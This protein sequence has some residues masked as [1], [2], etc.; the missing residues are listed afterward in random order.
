MVHEATL[1]DDRV[2]ERRLEEL[3]FALDW[4][5]HDL[6]GETLC[7]YKLHRERLAVAA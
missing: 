4:K 2:L 7:A 6:A 3:G 5:V 1:D